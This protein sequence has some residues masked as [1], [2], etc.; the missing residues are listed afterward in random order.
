MGPQNPEIQLNFEHIFDP[1]KF[2][3]IK[4]SFDV[5]LLCYKTTKG[6]NIVHANHLT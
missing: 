3:H 5:F 6:V 4:T 2:S 1:L